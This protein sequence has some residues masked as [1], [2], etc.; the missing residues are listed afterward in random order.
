MTAAPASPASAQV[1]SA[2]PAADINA[3]GT[4]TVQDISDFLS[5]SFAGCWPAAAAAAVERISGFCSHNFPL[6]STA[7]LG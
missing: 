4:P 6:A 5:A 2:E 7:G 1:V 3:S